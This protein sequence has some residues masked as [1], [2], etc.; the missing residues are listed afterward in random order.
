MYQKI[1][2]NMHQVRQ[3]DCRAEKSD[4]GGGEGLVNSCQAV[5]KSRSKMSHRG[6]DQ[7]GASPSRV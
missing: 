6:C 1:N 5:A 2:L 3:R 4:A 7:M